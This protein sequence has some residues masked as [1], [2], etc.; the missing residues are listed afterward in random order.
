MRLDPNRTASGI[1]PPVRATA[2]KPAAK[3]A[4]H[5]RVAIFAQLP[6]RSSHS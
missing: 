1:A 5:E 6:P 2:A 3:K 4:A